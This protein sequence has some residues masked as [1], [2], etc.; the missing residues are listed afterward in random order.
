VVLQQRLQRLLLHEQPQH[1]HRFT[2]S[3]V[4]A[5]SD[6]N[7]LLVVDVR[8]EDQQ[9]ELLGEGE[10]VGDGASESAFDQV[11]AVGFAGVLAIVAAKGSL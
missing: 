6:G 5:R 8:R 11:A 9:V 2:R 10:R 7:P 1:K 4:S 3:K